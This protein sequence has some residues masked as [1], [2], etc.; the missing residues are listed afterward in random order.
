MIRV[1]EWA[2][3]SYYTGVVMLLDEYVG[4][5]CCTLRILL[6][7]CW[8]FARKCRSLGFTEEGKRQEKRRKIC[9]DWGAYICLTKSV[10]NTQAIHL[11]SIRCKARKM[12]VEYARKCHSAIPSF[13]SFL[14]CLLASFLRS[15][16]HS[17]IHSFL[18]SFIHSLIH[19][20]KT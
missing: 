2:G 17:F 9:T 13:I 6:Q 11:F 20:F 10:V 4:N 14:A 5:A 8:N 3:L 12:P 19:S 18:P 7:S 16:I 15:F 1:G